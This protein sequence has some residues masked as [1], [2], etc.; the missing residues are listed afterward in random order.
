MILDFVDIV[1][2]VCEISRSYLNTFVEIK[3]N[4]Q[5]YLRLVGLESMVDSMQL[6]TIFVW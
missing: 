6:I 2:L 4:A 3:G 5:T 1:N